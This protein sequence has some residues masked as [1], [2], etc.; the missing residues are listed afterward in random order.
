MMGQ[1][2][3]APVSVVIR[4]YRCSLTIG[5]ALASVVQQSL[6]P[7]EVILIDDASG[8]E[9]WNVLRTM[10]STYPGWV[11]AIQLKSNR[12]AASAR[13]AG[14]AAARQPF[15]A[16]LDADDAWHPEKI[17]IQYEY[18]KRHP[19]VVLSGH[20]H[21]VLTQMDARLEWML[22]QGAEKSIHKWQLLLENQFVTPSVMLRAD[23][24]QRFAEGRRYMEDRL[25]WL[26]IVCGGAAVVLLNVD[27][28]ATYKLPY[29]SA[30]LSSNLWQMARSDIDNYRVLRRSGAL[31]WLTS[32]FLMVFSI[33]KFVRRMGLVLV[34][35]TSGRG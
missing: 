32:L 22:G 6:K 25:L 17:A 5:R 11:R 28:A 31:S 9:T 23:I 33:L 35:R 14:W 26:E 34:W 4:W 19:Q 12:G 18:M 8:D 30:G 1:D 21:R 15:I 10:E 16:F 2:L 13:N 29:G 7:A 27:L 3:S 20:Q 24:P